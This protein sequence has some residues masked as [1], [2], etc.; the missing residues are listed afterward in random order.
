MQHI[1]VRD[2]E[3]LR[4]VDAVRTL[5]VSLV[6]WHHWGAAYPDNAVARLATRSGW[7]GVDL[8]FVL[9][10]FL[11]SGLIFRE[12][13]RL[14]TF[15]ARRFL[16]RRGLKIYPA[17]YVFIAVSVVASGYLG[18]RNAGSFGPRVAGE[19]FFVQNYATPLWGHTW[20]LGVEEHFYLLLA[21][22]AVI[23]ARRGWL[24][25][26]SRDVAVVVV[27]V[28]ALVLAVRVGHALFVD[29][30]WERVYARTHVRI[31]SLLFGVLLAYV[32][33][34][35]RDRFVGFLARRRF[36]LGLLAGCLGSLPLVLHRSNA[37]MYTVGLS[38]ITVGF[39]LALMLV[40]T[41]A[42]TEWLAA[43][44]PGRLLA[45][46]GKHSYSAYL[47][48]APAM[49]VVGRA[50]GSLLHDAPYLRLALEL[51]AS[52]ALG[53]AVARLVEAP[54]LRLRDRVFPS[55]S[56]DVAGAAAI[57]RFSK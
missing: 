34:Y 29:Y 35:E 5:A 6:I 3:R 28:C 48:H 53:I 4:T 41:S 9:S 21:G 33:H 11:V 49:V 38:A 54:V 42:R 27:S 7:V 23:A 22:V 15:D 56:G 37:L 20:S 50:L 47:W 55:R 13:Q 10:G 32:Y 52:F 57:Y 30:R 31:D 36:A 44:R 24:G 8:F 25:R 2:A 1:E 14:G 19:I 18:L 46:T 40:L 39:G 16:V 51:A 17:F 45:Y 26:P 43:T 12:H